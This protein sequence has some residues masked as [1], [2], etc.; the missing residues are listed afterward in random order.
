MTW[1]QVKLGASLIGIA[2]AV[3]GLFA[4]ITSWMSRGQEI[5]RLHDWQNVV[6]IAATDATVQPDAKGVRKTLAPESVPSAIAALKRSLDTTTATLDGITR[7]AAD[8]K[9]RADN[10]DQAL[11]KATVVFEQRYASAEKRIAALDGRKPAASPAQQCANIMA[12]SKAAWE[13]WR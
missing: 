8:A 2:V 5:A 7:Q 10:A 11:A 13:G 1:G 9:V 12:D 3:A 6:V 4:L